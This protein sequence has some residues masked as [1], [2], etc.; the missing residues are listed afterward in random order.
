[1]ARRNILAGRTHIGAGF[2]P[3]RKHHLAAVE[4][5]VLLHE[6]RIG[7]FRHRCA[8]EDADGLARP[9][10]RCR[11]TAGLHPPADG[12][13]LRLALRQIAARDR[14]AVDGGIGERR[15]R[16][17]CGNVVRQ[18]APIG[19]GE[20]DGLDLGDPAHPRGD[21]ADGFI[22]R[23]HR[24]AEG[25]AIVGQLRHLPSQPSLKLFASKSSSGTA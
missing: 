25:K 16:Q 8:G 5:D 15:Q 2:Q 17:R 1:M 4:A 23:H 11:R 3:G 12:E 14:I 6:H 18:H 13:R 24:T 22:D 21:D 9:D 7:A 10:R 19:G 20:P